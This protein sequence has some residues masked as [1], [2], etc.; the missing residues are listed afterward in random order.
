VSP[1]TYFLPDLP[2]HRSGILTQFI[3]LLEGNKKRKKERKRRGKERKERKKKERKKE[4]WPSPPSSRAVL[5]KPF[6]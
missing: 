6:F 2:I 3:S 5:L 1:G 4:R